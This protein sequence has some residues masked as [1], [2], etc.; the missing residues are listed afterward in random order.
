MTI[1]SETRKA[2][3]YVGNSVA[4]VFSFGF[5]VFQKADLQVI[6]TLLADGTNTT[7]V[8]DTDYTVTL[9]A[10]QDASPGGSI[11]YNP[12]GVPMDA[13]KTLTLTSALAYKQLTDVTNGGGFYPQ[14]FEDVFDYLT[15]LAQQLRQSLMFTFRGPITDASGPAEMPNAATRALKFL[16]F[17]ASG[18]PI[19]ATGITGV[20]ASTFGASFV[21][22]ASAAAARVILG[23]TTIGDN[24]FRAADAAAARSIISAAATG[25]IGS[26]GLT[27]TT[28]RLLGR[29][30]AAT[31][32][33]E[34]ITVG[35][36]LALAGGV[37]SAVP[38]P[39][40]SAVRV[41][42]YNG[43]GSTATVVKRYSNVL[44]NVGTD[45]TYAD[46]AANGASATI[47]TTGVYAFGI[48]STGGAT[49]TGGISRNSAQLTTNIATIT[50]ANRLVLVYTS[51]GNPVTSSATMPLTAGDVIRP[52]CDGTGAGTAAQEQFF[53][54]RVA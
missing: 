2:G 9:N 30:T 40:N 39:P 16:G 33:V 49:N 20:T 3:P 15:I 35:T 23:A 54:T 10:D 36:G 12:L 18:N 50:A 27:M 32:P 6:Q 5:K 43:T 24:L 53:V 26:S 47:N 31:G 38:T 21:A 14:T 34:E 22:A 13:T 37:L 41:Q 19:A 7:L 29:T 1:S 17:D 42:N 28:A 51:G 4:T 48:T 11:T 46:S 8:L 44:E 45:I 52:H 25:A